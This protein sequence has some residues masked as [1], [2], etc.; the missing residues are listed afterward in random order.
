[1]RTYVCTYVC[2]YHTEKEDFTLSINVFAVIFNTMIIL[3]HR[4]ISLHFRMECII[5]IIII[6]TYPIFSFTSVT[7]YTRCRL[8]LLRLERI[9]DYLLMEEE[10]IRNQ[11]R[12]KPQE[13]RN[14]V[15][16]LMFGNV[17]S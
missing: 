6:Y 14:E 12:L 3:D 11:E 9:K 10:F 5:L 7:P 8:R 17:Y 1:M 15:R 4:Y 2:M 16:R 13:E